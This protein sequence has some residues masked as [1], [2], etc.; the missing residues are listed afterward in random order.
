MEVKSQILN[1]KVQIVI[2]CSDQVWFSLHLAKVTWSRSRSPEQKWFKA[3]IMNKCINGNSYISD[4]LSMVK[5]IRSSQYYICWVSL[6]IKLLKAGGL[7][8]T[9]SISSCGTILKFDLSIVLNSYYWFAHVCVRFWDRTMFT[10]C[11]LENTSAQAS[12]QCR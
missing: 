1:I 5:A 12:V 7:F 11:F 2:N 10:L 3:I 8:S 9:E 6:D 4:L